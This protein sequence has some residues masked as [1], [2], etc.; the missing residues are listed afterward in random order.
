MRTVLADLFLLFLKFIHLE[1]LDGGDVCQAGDHF[2]ICVS[3]RTNEVGAQ[4]LA[5][6]LA[7]SGYSSSFVDIR[8]STI[9]SI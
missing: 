9:F 8:V 1:T 3:E 4:Q 5:Q 7:P 6:F 2:F